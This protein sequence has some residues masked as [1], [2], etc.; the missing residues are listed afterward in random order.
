M[1]E[2]EAEMDLQERERFWEEV[3]NDWDTLHGHENLIW[4]THLNRAIQ[5]GS[6]TITQLEGKK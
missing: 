5:N 1:N 3:K 2:W 4:W 6:M